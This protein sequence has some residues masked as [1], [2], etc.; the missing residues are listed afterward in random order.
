MSRLL[1]AAAAAIAALALAAC[2]GQNTNAAATSNVPI[3]PALHDVTLGDPGAPVELIEYG[4]MMCPHCREFWM[5]D[6]PTLRTRYIDAGLVKYTFRDLTMGA[7]PQLSDAMTAITRCAGP[8]KY[9]DTVNDFFVRQFEVND[10]ARGQGGAGPL[11][12]EIGM[13][14]GLTREQ[15]VACIDSPAVRDYIVKQFNEKPADAAGLPSVFVN[16][17]FIA[18]PSLANVVAKI[19]EVLGARAPAPLDPAILNGAGEGPGTSAAAT[20]GAPAPTATPTATPS[21]H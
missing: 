18:N 2:G 20:P 7:A 10:A 11:L 14:A 15:I 6:M 9:Y 12:A 19:D 21:A 16:G 4:S 8:E 17:Q 1:A 5:V 3:N 13:R